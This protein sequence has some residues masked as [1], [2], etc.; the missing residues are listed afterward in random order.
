MIYTNNWYENDDDYN[1]ALEYL[2]YLQI[3][4]KEENKN[5]T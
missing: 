1:I 5:G 3:K 2:I 4:D